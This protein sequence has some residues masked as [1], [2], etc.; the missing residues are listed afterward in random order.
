MRRCCLSMLSN[1]AT[2]SLTSCELVKSGYPLK[3]RL[4]LAPRAVYAELK[5]FFQAAHIK[6]STFSP[7]KT[8]P[9]CSFLKCWKH[10]G[11]HSFVWGTG[12]R[13][14]HTGKGFSGARSAD[15][16]IFQ[17]ISYCNVSTSDWGF[18]RYFTR[19]RESFSTMS[20]KYTLRQP[21][22]PETLYR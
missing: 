18:W 11:I 22:V 19:R 4:L 1:S 7:K 12:H 17:Q 3:I 15:L 21:G 16:W 20:L 6:V 5:E 2:Q 8:Y 14:Y 9:E 13:D 10:L